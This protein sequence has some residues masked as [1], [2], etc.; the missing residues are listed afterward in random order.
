MAGYIF[1]GCVVILIILAIVRK[2]DYIVIHTV[3]ADDEDEKK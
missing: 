3:Y 2:D 1:I